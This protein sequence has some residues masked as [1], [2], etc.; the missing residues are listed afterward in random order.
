MH[1]E[2]V[3]PSVRIGTGT[4]ADL[5]S[6][7]SNLD[8]RSALIVTDVGLQRTPWPAAAAASCGS[9]GV[10]T[11]VF[12][13]VDGTPT[14]AVV[15]AC[16]LEFTGGG[17]DALV[18]VGGG[19]AIDTAK[20]CA[21]LVAHG[22]KLREYEGLGHFHRPGP[23]V[24]AVPTTPSGGADVS[25]HAVIACAKRRYAVSGPHLRPAAVIVDQA[26]WHTA[27]TDVIG[28][29]VID[30]FIHGIEAYL[31]L[32]ATAE[33]DA[34]A[35][36]GVGDVFRA[37]GIDDP[38]LARGCMATGTAMSHANAGLLH[39]L[40][41]PL[42]IEFGVMH[43]RANALVAA[44]ALELI[45]AAE[46]VR[47]RVIA[48]RCGASDLPEAVADL[49]TRYEVSTSFPTDLSHREAIRLAEMTSAY[50]PLLDNAPLRIS[51]AGMAD[52]YRRALSA[53]GVRSVA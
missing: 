45:S 49:C 17:Y 50:Q 47:C 18:A 46:P 13:Q 41:Y 14:A 2:S 43:G 53:S 5:G 21:G 38:R 12:A 22:G 27:P 4:L 40:G 23:P 20:A 51:C 7:V 39:A 6:V 10:H 34:L 15:S 35:T 26:T 9:A 30:A 31:A 32:A 29:A 11:G 37:T 24:I 1:A 25:F 16:Q 28:A 19:S 44:A 33:T 36:A 8:A 42:S 52:I 3:S 48:A